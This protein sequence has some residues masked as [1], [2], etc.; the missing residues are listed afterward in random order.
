MLLKKWK[1]N[2]KKNEKENRATCSHMMISMNII[3]LND[4]IYLWLFFIAFYDVNLILFCKILNHTRY[5]DIY[6]ETESDTLG[7]LKYCYKD[8]KTLAFIL[9]ACSCFI[10]YIYMWTCFFAINAVTCGYSVK[11]F[12]IT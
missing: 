5:F 7:I 8:Q 11:F 6:L 3:H 2:F 9:D 1:Q 10:A 12:R 4:L